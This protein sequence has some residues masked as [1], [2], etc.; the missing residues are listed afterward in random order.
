MGYRPEDI[1]D[2]LATT[3]ADL[4]KQEL[5][6]VLDH[7]EYFWSSL[8]DQDSVVIDGGTSIQRKVVFD[9]AGTAKYSGVYDT[10]EYKTK[11]VIQTIDVHWAKLTANASWDE[12]EI[13]NQQNS[14]KGY[15]DLVQTRKD[16]M[17]IDLADL[18]EETMIVAPASITDKTT[19][20][21]LPYYLRVLDSTGTL[22]T[23]SDFNGSTVTFTGG[24]TSTVCAGI[25]SA[26]EAKWR[27]WCGVYTGVNNALLKIMRKALIK[28]NMKY[29]ILLKSP[30]IKERAL[31]YR[32]VA[33][34]DT[35]LDLMELVDN[36]D[37]NHVSTSKEVMGGMLVNE[38]NLVRVNK[39]PVIPLDTLDSATYSPIYFMDMAWF[40]PIVHDG[41]WMKTT[42]PQNHKPLQHTVYSINVDGAHQVLVENMKRC[43][44]VLHKSS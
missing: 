44:F 31:K 30:L 36:K 17:Y 38:G 11:D 24:G 20:F 28:T 5:Q 6:Y 42:P 32:A 33:G 2:L 21:T 25:D 3:L 34:T 22:N 35:V 16:Q 37:D 19:P 10:D 14:T 41:Y 1:E 39:I 4:P 27:N 7:D 8:F 9:T 40:K 29:P 15:I 13:V 26:V 43:G 12:W 18:M 23:G